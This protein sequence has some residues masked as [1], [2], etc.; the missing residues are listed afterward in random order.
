MVE[1]KDLVYA[2]LGAVADANIRLSA[3]IV[4]FLANTG[5][6]TADATGNPMVRL[7]TIQMLYDQLRSDAMEN[8]VADSIG[9]EIPLLS[10]YPLSA[11][12]VS[13]T[14]V[15]FGA[16]IVSMRET[17][18]GLSICTQVSSKNQRQHKGNA[19][20]TYEIE[21]NS[22]PISEGLARFVDTLNTQAIPRR[23]HSKPVDSSGRR[24]TG[25]ELEEYRHFMALKEREEGLLSRINDL[26]ESIRVQNSTLAMETGMNFDEYTAHCV[27]LNAQGAAE[28]V[29]E[30]YT[31]IGNLRTVVADLEAQLNTLRQE[32]IAVKITGDDV[33][34]N[35][36]Q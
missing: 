19:Q 5:D 26:R 30:V 21:L 14:K 20:I 15:S 8:T 34:E 4:D 22:T 36:E 13:K 28:E 31:Q 1:L 23:I 17:K 6:L 12:K 33:P 9:L 29:P 7:R 27:H 2:P 18:E 3:N 11:L 35:N 24:L 32:I 16:E 10:V 25:R